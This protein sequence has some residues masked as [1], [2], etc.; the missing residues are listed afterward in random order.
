M[1]TLLY[2][3]QLVIH[4]CWC[5]IRHSIPAELDR[6]ARD[7]KHPVFCPL[8]HEWVISKT[9]AE[10][11]RAKRLEAEREATF[12]RNANRERLAELDAARRTNAALRGHLTRWRKPRRQR[13]VP[14]GRVQ[15]PLPERPG[16]RRHRA[17]GLAR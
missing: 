16:P 10:R 7:N 9:D 15:A 3:G 1:E 17:P 8:G 12:W 13:R 5:G 14:G 11:E 4:A 2:S 6:Q